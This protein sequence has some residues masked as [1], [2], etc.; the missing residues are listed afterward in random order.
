MIV[1]G[2][3]QEAQNP[4]YDSMEERLARQMSS[5]KITSQRD[6]I[7]VE[8]ICA[9]SDEIKALQEKI[10]QAYLNKERRSQ[11]VESQYR[12]F[13]YVEEEALIERSMLRQKE[14]EDHANREKLRAEQH[15]RNI[16][17]KVSLML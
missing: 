10:N 14:R 4:K 3:G 5:M 8:R 9:D 13:K 2:L 6:K 17:K 1:G 11:M 16:H 15:A 7:E 12:Q